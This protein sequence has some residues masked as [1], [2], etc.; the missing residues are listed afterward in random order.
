MQDY[1]DTTQSNKQSDLQ[2]F[3]RS[4]PEAP[5]KKRML[6]PRLA[7]AG[8]AACLILA[9]VLAWR[10]IPPKPTYVP[11]SELSSTDMIKHPLASD[12]D[13]KFNLAYL[14]RLTNLL[15]QYPQEAEFI[16]EAMLPTVACADLSLFRLTYEGTLIGISAAILPYTLTDLSIR[17]WYV[18]SGYELEALSRFQ[19]LS[20]SLEWNGI[21]VTHGLVA[22]E[23]SETH[24]FTFTQA[25]VR[26]YLEVDSEEPID[27]TEL[28][29][30]L[31]K[32]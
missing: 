12:S 23:E 30:I 4:Q 20:D 16:K 6:L 28:L 10:L 1:V 26:C 22:A 14:I 15:T 25:N 24:L 27:P 31:F 19:S 17:L 13:I 8:C 5:R 9:A 11:S 32:S 18:D 21:D 3:Y 7:A 29:E 2:K